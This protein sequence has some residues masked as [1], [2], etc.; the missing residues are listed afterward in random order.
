[1]SNYALIAII[2]F[3]IFLVFGLIILLHKNKKT[4]LALSDLTAERELI[5]GLQTSMRSD[6]SKT[7]S[8]QKV[9]MQNISK[10]AAER[11]SKK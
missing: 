1:M 3:D 5:S 9:M 6:I 4:D 11:L 10:I 7:S 2:V 8:E